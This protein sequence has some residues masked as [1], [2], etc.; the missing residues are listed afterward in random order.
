MADTQSLE[1]SK[2]LVSRLMSTPAS[3][4]TPITSLADLRDGMIIRHENLPNDARFYF[5]VDAA[6]PDK[7]GFIKV[8]RIDGTSETRLTSTAFTRQLYSRYTGELPVPDTTSATT[9]V[10]ETVPAPESAASPVPVK[11]SKKLA[12]ALKRAPQSA[13]GRISSVADLRGGMIIRTDC[14]SNNTH[15]YY[16][17]TTTIPDD[18]G[19]IRVIRIDGTGESVITVDELSQQFYS[20]YTGELPDVGKPKTPKRSKKSPVEPVPVPAPIEPAPVIDRQIERLAELDK[21]KRKPPAEPTDAARIE[22]ETRLLRTA[23]LAVAYAFGGG[24]ISEACDADYNQM[25]SQIAERVVSGDITHEQAVAEIVTRIRAD[26]ESVPPARKKAAPKAG[27]EKPVAI[28]KSV[29]KEIKRIDARI[30]EMTEKIEHFL[31]RWEEISPTL[32][33]NEIK[34]VATPLRPPSKRPQSE[35]DFQPGVIPPPT[36]ERAGGVGY[37]SYK[38]GELNVVPVPAGAK[39]PISDTLYVKDGLCIHFTKDVATH[40]HFIFAR[41]LG[42]KPDALF[43]VDL[44]TG[45]CYLDESD[46]PGFDYVRCFDL[47]RPRLGAPFKAAGGRIAEPSQLLKEIIETFHR[48]PEKVKITVVE[49]ASLA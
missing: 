36:K 23:C 5:Y 20:Y 7:G 49:G 38:T 3:A 47:T 13:W 39:L 4:W 22:E 12:V 1:F 46:L 11:L 9:S 30:D 40:L 31:S 44:K 18:D 17:V 43:G 2:E 24:E 35:E 28:D 32:P 27:A 16:Y 21:K 45:E 26:A 8:S 37:A 14:L 41:A 42:T 25:V 34:F 33:V 6:V 29:A 10:P 19:V 48:T 15:Y